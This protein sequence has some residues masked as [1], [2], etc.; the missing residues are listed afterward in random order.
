M[1]W[2][3]GLWEKRTGWEVWRRE[4]ELREG[5]CPE[6]GGEESEWRMKPGGGP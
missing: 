2:G 4:M 6:D 1:F 5:S 3:E